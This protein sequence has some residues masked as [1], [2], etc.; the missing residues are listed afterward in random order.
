MSDYEL[1]KLKHDFNEARAYRELFK[2]ATSNYADLRSR[3]GLDGHAS[4]EDVLRKADSL[5]AEVAAIRA[6]FPA[7]C[8]DIPLF[9]QGL[10]DD[11]A[12]LEDRVSAQN[13]VIDHYQR[14]VERLRAALAQAHCDLDADGG[15]TEREC[16]CDDCTDMR[17]EVKP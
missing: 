1:A 17:G 2:H 16:E 14:E 6:L 9:I 3:L 5:K 4:V 7:D 10:Q 8:T 11:K 13:D 15:M 12:K